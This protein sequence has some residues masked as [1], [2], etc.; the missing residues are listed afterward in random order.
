M[1]KFFLVSIV[2]IS[3]LNILF[4]NFKDLLLYNNPQN[5]SEFSC[6][7]DFHKDFPQIKEVGFFTDS[8]YYEYIWYK[9]QNSTIP[10]LI[11]PDDNSKYFFCYSENNI[12]NI[13]ILNK[14]TKPIKIYS[15]NLFFLENIERENK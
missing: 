2:F 6:L 3:V 11:N 4:F 15:K 12:C 8:D 1:N 10:V 9:I 7:K 14:Q 5:T 13:L